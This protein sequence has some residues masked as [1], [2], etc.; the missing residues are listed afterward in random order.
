MKFDRRTAD[1]LYRV[2]WRFRLCGICRC[3][4]AQAL[5]SELAYPVH[6]PSSSGDVAAA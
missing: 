2:S 1:A 5:G 6:L 3:A 4:P